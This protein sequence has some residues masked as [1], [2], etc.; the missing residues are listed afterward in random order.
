MH[1]RLR[2][3]RFLEAWS[4]R[5]STRSVGRAAD[6]ALRR[7]RQLPRHGDGVREIATTSELALE[8]QR[9]RADGRRADRLQ[10][11][12]FRS[13]STQGRGLHDERTLTRPSTST[14]STWPAWTGSDVHAL[15]RPCRCRSSAADMLEGHAFTGARRHR[16]IVAS[17]RATPSG[18]RRSARTPLETGRR[19]ALDAIERACGVI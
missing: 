3:G 8:L 9:R 1:A 14:R 2:A 13:P 6:W 10:L 19:I 15:S 16:R 17:R 12:T 4:P 18:A 11:E 5:C 7:L